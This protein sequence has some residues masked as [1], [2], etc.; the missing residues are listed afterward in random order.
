MKQS[1]TSIILILVALFSSYAATANDKMYSPKYFTGDQLLPSEKV[2]GATTL[3]INARVNIVLVNSTSPI[4]E[5][6]GKS[7]FAGRVTFERNGNTLTV[8]ADKSKDLRNAGT[9]YIS[10]NEL[11]KIQVNNEAEIRTL[12]TLENP[13]L[14]LHI[15][16]ECQF[17]I[18]NV[19]ALNVIP[20]SRY[21][22]EGSREE[23]LIPTSVFRRSNK[24]AF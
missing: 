7:S 18:H 11:R 17:S 15:N 14:D 19:G 13:S 9:I 22:I 16:S 6:T 10:A 5:I 3:V 21:A 2:L 20:N 23:R 1:I 4:L 12:N 24:Y 8:N